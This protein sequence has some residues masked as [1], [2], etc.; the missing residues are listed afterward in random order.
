MF[1]LEV[2]WRSSGPEAT[3]SKIPVTSTSQ[4]QASF[5]LGHLNVYE[6]C[7]PH[8]LYYLPSSTRSTVHTNQVF[9]SHRPFW[10]KKKKW[11]EISPLLSPPPGMYMPSHFHRAEGFSIP[12]AGRSASSFANSCSLS[13]SR[14][15]K[16]ILH[17]EKSFA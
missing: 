17:R 8:Y 2:S 9:C 5:A 1:S 16:K 11:L 6:V 10:L 14:R 4:E 12:T 7:A 13:H 15:R 3:Q